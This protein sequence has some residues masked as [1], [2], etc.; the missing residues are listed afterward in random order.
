MKTFGISAILAIGAIGVA[1]SAYPVYPQ[2]VGQ[3]VVYQ[4]PQR[5]VYQQVQPGQVVYQQPMVQNQVYIP[6]NTVAAPTT[7]VTGQLPR[8]GS[9]VTNAGR[10]YYQP[11]DYD[12][13][14]DSGLYIGLSAAYSVSVSGG[15]TA[16]YQGE[17]DAWYVP[18]SFE[19]STFAS[20]TVIPLQVSLGA[21]INNDVRVDFSYT[22]YGDIGYSDIVMT[23]D[24]V[25]SYI[26]A[27]ATGGAITSNATMINVYYNIDSYTGFLLGGNLR[28]Y[29]GVGVGLSLNTIGDYVIYDGTFY[30]EVPEDGLPGLDPGALT[31][32][33]DIYAYHNGGT[34]E[35]LAYMLE[36]GV[37]TDLSGGLKLDFFVRYSGLG[38]VKPSGSIVVSQTEW[39]ADG[40]G[41]EG[42]APYDS[43]FHYTNWYESGNM[44]TVD[45]GVRLRLQF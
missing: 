44:S 24:G 10:Q 39:L 12:R 23:S 17:K 21:A 14:A 36:A 13:L 5:V 40:M 42:P 26:E 28:P 18:G 8:V 22:R 35:N 29:I 7:R 19:Q 11:S 33:S 6:Q 20:D 45:V 31:G 32:I 38:K 34:T 41:G 27:Q 30:A 1:H 2:P 3:P 37:T 4:Q 16:D 15:M 25:G 9:N 43:V